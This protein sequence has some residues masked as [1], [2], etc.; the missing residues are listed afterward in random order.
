M[1]GI[2]T[3]AW[4]A[5]AVLSTAYADSAVTYHVGA[6]TLVGLAAVNVV[7]DGRLD[8]VT[9]AR[10]DLSIRILPGDPARG[11]GDALAIPAQDDA[12]RAA[13]G[14][15]NGDGVPDLLVIGH[16]NTLNVRLGLGGGGFGAVA[17]YGLRNHGNHLAVIDLN[18]DGFADVVAVHDGS[19]QPVFVTTFLGS[20]TG[21]LH[22][23]WE[24]GTP[25]FTSEGIATGDFDGDG[26]TDVAVALGG[27]V[28]ASALAFHGL[29]TGE[30]TGP[31]LVPTVS[32]NASQTDGTSSIA[33]GDLDRDGRDDL[34][35]SC[36]DLTNQL[37]IRRST[38]SGFADAVKIPLPSPVAVALGDLNGDGKLDA[39]ASNLSQGALSL[40][41]GRGDGTF[42]EP[43][44]V[45]AGPN[46]AYLAVADLDG[47]GLDDIAVTDLGDDAIR[48]IHSPASVSI[49]PRGQ[50]ASLHFVLNG[51]QPVADQAHFRFD[52]PAAGPFTIELFN[53]AGRRAADAIRGSSS[54]G[55]HEVD[56]D[57]RALGPGVYVARLT[58]AGEHAALRLVRIP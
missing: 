34:V 36:F 8:L 48:V 16:D 39:V 38:P 52:L 24:V 22:Q 28:R 5:C 37:V 53:V 41:Q 57:A 51:A 27:D 25:Y 6:T 18:H 56:W 14:D 49:P 4:L 9:V 43:V 50:P 19:G 11:F 13:A 54:A 20:A 12:R 45:P 35:I 32:S 2:V 42:D 30:F 3:I 17:S 58:A 33:A 15:V 7:G 40:L 31:V 23:V 29:G 21:D 47:D 55:L 46:P 10:S 44:T 1:R 26:K